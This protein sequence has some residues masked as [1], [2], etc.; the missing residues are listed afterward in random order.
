MLYCGS[1]EYGELGNPSV[2]TAPHYFEF[3]NRWIWDHS[4]PGFDDSWFSV[5]NSVRLYNPGFVDLTAGGDVWGY[6]TGPLLTGFNYA[7]GAPQGGTILAVLDD[8]TV[9]G[10]GANADGQLGVGNTTVQL[11]GPLFSFGNTTDGLRRVWTAGTALR[12]HAGGR[13]ALVLD[14][15]GQIWSAGNNNWGQLGRGSFGVNSTSWGLVAPPPAGWRYIDIAAGPK[16]SVFVATNDAVLTYRM[17]VEHP[18]TPFVYQFPPAAGHLDT[19][20][21]ST[22]A[23]ITHL[24]FA[25]NDLDDF[26][27]TD[28]LALLPVGAVIEFESEPDVIGVPARAASFQ[29]TDVV[30]D[31]GTYLDV[32]VAFASGNLTASF[33][34][35]V[36]YLVRVIVD[37]VLTPRLFTSLYACGDGS[38]G[39]LGPDIFSSSVVPT[40]VTGSPCTIV[41]VQQNGLMTWIRTEAGGLYA[42]GTTFAGGGILQQLW[43]KTGVARTSFATP[44]RIILDWVPQEDGSYAV[45]NPQTIL[46]AKLGYC[47]GMSDQAGN[48]GPNVYGGHGEPHYAVIGTDGI[49]RQ[50]GSNEN[51][52]LANNSTAF[53]PHPLNKMFYAHTTFGNATWL[54]VGDGYMSITADGHANRRDYPLWN[55]GDTRFDHISQGEFYDY[56]TLLH[57]YHNDV[58]W[59]KAVEVPDAV[60]IRSNPPYYNGPALWWTPVDP[61]HSKFHAHQWI[62]ITDSAYN[63]APGRLIAGWDVPTFGQDLTTSYHY[64]FGGVSTELS[65]NDQAGTFPTHL[66]QPSSFKLTAGYN[67]IAWNWP[68]DGSFDVYTDVPVTQIHFVRAGYIV[69][70]VSAD[71]FFPVPGG[72]G[73]PV[74]TGSVLAHSTAQFV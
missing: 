18:D 42:M 66:F 47:S 74:R 32:P 46:C 13:H 29:T 68:I 34:L 15:L 40:R 41:E 43:D 14:D 69:N 67:F 55:D 60:D 54:T 9:A 4:S 21:T 5:H 44:E 59:G 19:N 20:K 24:Y 25:R 37:G 30:V 16:Q 36:F 1:N 10:W 11:N 62:F 58:S 52:L 38:A 51:G 33:S 26:T 61:G 70:Y 8:G 71:Q 72:F 57:S 28:N 2:D 35:G 27:T 22:M 7:A 49:L 48:P 73:G 6:T 31:H 50:W 23:S 63:V 64:D 56:P 39:Q 12:V 65:V 17:S 3:E 53:N 45:A